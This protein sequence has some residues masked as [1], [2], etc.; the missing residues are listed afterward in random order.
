VHCVSFKLFFSTVAWLLLM[1]TSSHAA[2][3]ADSNTVSVEYLEGG[4]ER[5]VV[6]LHGLARTSSSMS[7]LGDA[8]K[9]EGYSVALVDYPSRDY[10]VEVLSNL[11]VEAGLQRCRKHGHA[12]L[13]FVTHSLGGILIRAYLTEHV[14]PELERIVMLAPPNHGSA[15]VDN[16]KGIPGVA[17]LN[18]PAF[19]QIGTDELSLPVNLGKIA[20]DTAVIAGTRSVNL[21][22]SIFLENPDDGKVSLES[23]RLEGMCAM[24][25]IAVSHPF[26]MKDEVAIEQTLVYLNTGEFSLSSA[27]YPDCA[28]R[29]S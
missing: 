18:G 20:V 5:C 27:E 4:S 29:K 21:I 28:S 10:S 3:D 19:L 8:L 7:K 15:V 26:I 25:A 17:W 22:L 2:G 9:S 6:L 1:S 11:A 24:L 16:V 12:R 13:Y 23:A 14:I